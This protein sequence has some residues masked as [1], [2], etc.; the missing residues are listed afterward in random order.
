MILAD[1]FDQIYWGVI[2]KLR[3]LTNEGVCKPAVQGK[4]RQGR[5]GAE[6]VHFAATCGRRFGSTGKTGGGGHATAAVWRGRGHGTGQQSTARAYCLVL[7]VARGRF[8]AAFG[9]GR[10]WAAFGRGRSGRRHL[11]NR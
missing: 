11:R 4:P 5:L 8:W 10:F 7:H 6:R 9:R 1:K 3:A 2:R